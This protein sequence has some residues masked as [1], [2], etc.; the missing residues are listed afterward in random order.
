MKITSLKDI[1][2]RKLFKQVLHDEYSNR[3]PQGIA[4]LLYNLFSWDVSR[5]L[6]KRTANSLG[7]R[8]SKEL[9]SKINKEVRN[10]SGWNICHMGRKESDMELLQKHYPS[11]GGEAFVE[12]YTPYRGIDAV[13][14]KAHKMRL[15]LLP[16]TANRIRQVGKERQ[17]QS[18]KLMDD[19]LTNPTEFIPDD[20]VKLSW[21]FFQIPCPPDLRGKHYY[22]Q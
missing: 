7:L 12:T 2:D 13:I 16:E 4:L 1:P 20:E 3:G 17:K 9:L 15:K 18:R 19:F 14:N 22:G 8:V 21:S 11:M 10:P 5:T 6:I